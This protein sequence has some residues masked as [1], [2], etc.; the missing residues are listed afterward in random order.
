MQG[1]PQ[2]EGL[3]DEAWL[4][5]SWPLDPVDFSFR[6]LVTSNVDLLEHK[7]FENGNCIVNQGDPLRE[8][9]YVVEGEVEI[10]HMMESDSDDDDL[11]DG[12]DEQ[13]QQPT[14]SN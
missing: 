11:E 8:I 1:L 5:E 9:Y 2:D 13:V 6:N 7:T 12:S 14:Q 10:V 3:A 4:L